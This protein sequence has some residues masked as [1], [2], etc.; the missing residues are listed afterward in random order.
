MNFQ[1]LASV[2][3]VLSNGE[4]CLKTKKKRKKQQL[5]VINISSICIPECR[6]C[7]LLNP[8]SDEELRHVLLK[9]LL[10]YITL[11]AYRMKPK[12]QFTCCI[13]YKYYIH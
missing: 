1:M 9:V 5:A 10:E 3:K 4:K 11:F 12:V 13:S 7:E 6:V 2:L 8:K